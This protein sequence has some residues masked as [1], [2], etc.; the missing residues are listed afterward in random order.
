M[1][2][3]TEFNEGKT[4][5]ENPNGGIPIGSGNT[6]EEGETKFGDFVYSNRFKVDKNIINQF[7]L[8]GYTANKSYAD[9][10]KSINNKF[11]DRNDKVSNETKDTLLARLSEAH[12]YVKLQDNLKT[13]ST[14]VPDMMNG[15]VPQGFE[16]FAPE[17]TQM[18]LGG[19]TGGI[20]PSAILGAATGGMSL[21]N[22]AKG[23]TST[24]GL[25]AGISGITTGLGVGSM[26]GPIGAGVGAAVGLGAGLI[27]NAKAKKEAEEQAKNNHI[28]ASSTYQNDFAL[29]GI[30]PK[31]KTKDDNII[32]DEVNIGID[33]TIYPDYIN[34]QEAAMT[35]YTAPTLDISST[36]VDTSGYTS[37]YEK[38]NLQPIADWTKNNFGDVLRLAPLATNALQL[39]NLKKPQR[40]T[41][42]RLSNRYIPQ[43]TDER[44]LQNIVG[45]ELDNTANALTG[46]TGGSAGALRA[47]LLAAGLNRGKALSSAY[48]QANDRNIQQN[49][50]AQ[51]FNAGID[52]TNL[53][54]S[55]QELDINDRNT[56]A[57]DNNK[58]KLISQIGTDIGNIGKE[59]VYKKIARETFGY[60]WDG[61]YYVDGNGN[62]KT[63]KEVEG[64]IDTQINQTKQNMFGGYLK[65]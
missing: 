10:S 42:N 24:D 11:K 52:Q 41:L 12:E 59:E 44:A 47:N 40:E 8:P 60:T 34:S 65:K 39:A 31:F 28:I 6:V 16:E 32:P 9:A 21:L 62:K 4:H 45:N 37:P 19:E 49:Q 43:Y 46:A 36:K 25:Q 50:I 17:Q 27:G 53:Q 2:K 13:N 33:P 3:L 64:K 22:Q 14:S 48:M 29:G 38:A 58:S 35:E 56:A 61:K 51:Q 30:L 1:K 54:Q 7:N 20:D 26:F 5:S 23:N 15:T 57:Y 55:N 63:A 18:F